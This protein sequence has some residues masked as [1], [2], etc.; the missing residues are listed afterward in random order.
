MTY[1]TLKL[2]DVE[3]KQ[4]REILQVV[5]TDQL[6][7]TVQLPDGEEII[8]QPKTPLKPLPILKGY[9]PEGWKDA[10]YQ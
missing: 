7:L 4:L 1:K 5:S 6:A 8:I 9:V 10:I 3:K 2:K